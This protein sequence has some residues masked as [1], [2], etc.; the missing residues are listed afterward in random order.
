VDVGRYFPRGEQPIWRQLLVF[1]FFGAVCAAAVIVGRVV[2]PV[3]NPAINT[4][5]LPHVGPRFYLWE[6]KPRGLG[7]VFS[8]S[9]RHSQLAEDHGE[10]LQAIMA[11]DT[12]TLIQVVTAEV[13]KVSYIRQIKMERFTWLARM[14]AASVVLFVVLMAADATLKKM[15]PPTAV[16]IQGPVRVD[17]PPQKFLLEAPASRSDGAPPAKGTANSR[18]ARGK[19]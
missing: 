17:V 3:G 15:E 16:Q 6:L 8:N 7:R 12:A 5:L 11:S 10:Y 1:A 2:F 13:L 9:A 4:R 18:K 14:L 19:E